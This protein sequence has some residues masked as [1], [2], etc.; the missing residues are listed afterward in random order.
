MEQ[1]QQLQSKIEDETKELQTLQRE[2]QKIVDGRQRLIE[3]QN[4]NELV[5]KEF[6][7]L[8]ANAKVYKLIGAVLVPQTTQESK[9]NVNKRLNFILNELK[10]V[11]DLVK[12]NQNKQ[13]QKRALIQKFQE[14]LYHIMQAYQQSLQK[15]QQ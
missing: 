11:E 7:L 4:E 8:E 1:V 13:L 14:Q 15:Q 6:D 12:D 3:Q 9:E 5:K 10:K 2:L